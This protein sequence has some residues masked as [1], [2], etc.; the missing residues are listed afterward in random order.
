[1]LARIVSFRLKPDTL[2]AFNEIIEKEALPLVRQQDGFVT[3]VTVT[4]S[5]TFVRFVTAWES[6]S[7]LQN[8]HF[9]GYQQ[10]WPRFTSLIDGPPT[11]TIE[12][13]HV[14]LHSILISD[15]KGRRQAVKFHAEVS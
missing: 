6:E 3:A 13:I 12:L 5:D 15:Y 4:E 1:M 11:V 9:G 7:A 2:N 8:F 10:L 14:P